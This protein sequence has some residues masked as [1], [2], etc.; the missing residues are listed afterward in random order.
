MRADDPALVAAEY[1]TEHGLAARSSIYGH[2]DRDARDVVLD[3]LRALTPSRVLEVGCGWGA[4]A[5]RIEQEVDCTV[6]ALDLSPRMVELARERGVDAHVADLQEIPFADGGFDAVVAA[7]M[8]YHVPDLGRGLSEIARVLRPGGVLVAVTNGSRDL[9]EVWD[10][11][12]RDLEPRGLTFRT[13][14]GEH[15]LRRHFESVRRID[16]VGTVRFPD[17]DAIRRYVG[18]SALGRSFVDRVPDSAAPLVATKIV[19][20]FV[21]RT[22]MR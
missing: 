7:W 8:L 5:A 18:S 15:H 13:E 17:A 10:L 20:V 2:A 9:H 16:V 3:E 11:V 21:A 22:R 12:G 19:G 4:L 6:V 14:N 1:A